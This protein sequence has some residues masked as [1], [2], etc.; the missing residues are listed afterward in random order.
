MKTCV[1]FATVVLAGTL[2]ASTRYV[3]LD[4]A[5]VVPFTNGWASAATN[6]QAAVDIAA[7]NDTIIVSNGVYST[8][9]RL[10]GAALVTNRVDVPVPVS[11]RSLSG[12]GAT[13]IEGQGPM[14]DGAVRCIFLAAGARLEGFTLSNGFASLW[15]PELRDS[16]GG[17]LL[18]SGAVVSNCIITCCGA[19]FGGGI[20]RGTVWNTI[21]TRSTAGTGNGGGAYSCTMYNCLLTHNDGGQG[22]GAFACALYNCTVASNRASYGGGVRDSG[23]YNSI[24]YHNSASQAGADHYGLTC[25]DTCTTPGAYLAGA[26]IMTN[27]PAFVDVANDYH[28]R[29]NSPCIDAGSNMP[30]MASAGDLDGHARVYGERVDMGCYEFVPEP[31]GG[32]AAVFALLWAARRMRLGS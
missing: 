22:G 6:I 10:H 11:L 21:V 30:W 7:T 8:G 29:T 4:G 32:A 14:G 17:A 5:H 12:P 1:C 13:V 26:R 9:G 27:D 24:V 23:A 20:R 16:G 31:C 19:S 28:L 18:E 15:S 25:Y 2:S 3:S